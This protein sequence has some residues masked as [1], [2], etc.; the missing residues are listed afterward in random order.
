MLGSTELSIFGYDD[1]E[2]LL[3]VAYDGGDHEAPRT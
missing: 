3:L 1:D 2:F